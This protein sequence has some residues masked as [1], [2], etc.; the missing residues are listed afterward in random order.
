MVTDSSIEDKPAQSTNQPKPFTDMTLTL[1]PMMGHLTTS[2]TTTINPQFTMSTRYDMNMY[3]YESDIAVGGEFRSFGSATDA[4]LNKLVGEKKKEG[5]VL[6]ARMSMRNGVGIKLEGKYKRALWSVG[7]ETE[8]G[9]YPRRR[10]G[11]ELQ[12]S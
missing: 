11:I 2:Y 3:S 10:V 1:N 9:R 7:M 8:F 12:L 6:K 4:E 5:Q